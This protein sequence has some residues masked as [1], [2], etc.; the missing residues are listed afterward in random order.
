M[1]QLIRKKFAV[2]AASLMLAVIPVALPVAVSAADDID[3]RKNLACGTN[4]DTGQ[5]DAA[6][7]KTDTSNGSTQVNNII[8][9]VV[10]IFSALVGIVSVIMI[11]VGGFKYI[12]SG[13]DSSNVQSAKNTIIYAVIG[14]VVVA[15]AQFVVQFVLSKVNAG[16]NT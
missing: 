7:S 8:K 6:C 10:N 2:I 13:G 1:L 12:T 15:M 3:I 4:F 14:L 5:G 9:A 11:I 16:T